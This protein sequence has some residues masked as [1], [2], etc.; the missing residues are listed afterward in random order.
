MK[1]FFEDHCYSIDDVADGQKL[2]VGGNVVF[3]G[4]EIFL[5]A[6]IKNI[7][8]VFTSADTIF[9]QL[10][11]DKMNPWLTATSA[12]IDPKLFGRIYAIQTVIDQ[13]EYISKDTDAS[14]RR[15]KLYFDGD[16]P[17]LSSILEDKCAE[18]VEI[19]LVTQIYLKRHGIDCAHMSGVV[20][21]HL[22]GVYG[23]CNDPHSFNIIQL[24]DRTLLYDPAN[25]LQHEDGQL[26]PRIHDIP[27]AL[28]NA[29]DSR[30][31][32][33]PA[34]MELQALFSNYKALYGVSEPT[35]CYFD[36]HIVRAPVTAAAPPPA[37]ARKLA[38]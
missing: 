8:S 9:D 24:K 12:S 4:N 35:M 21:W 23:E 18:C 30:A 20:H 11:L 38:L 3:S 1:R 17:T 34:L 15:H 5:T 10:S 33:G 16:T 2:L 32:E 7:E 29:W 13:G 14:Q 37:P 31:T 25:P 6:D 26:I 28:F 19:S 36:D 22:A 27:A